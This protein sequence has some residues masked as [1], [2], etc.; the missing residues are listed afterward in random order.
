MAY[1]NAGRNIDKRQFRDLWIVRLKPL[2]A[3]SQ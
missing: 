2:L 3:P 1:S